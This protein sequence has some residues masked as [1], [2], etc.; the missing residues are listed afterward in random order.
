MD[1]L[2]E[3]QRVWLK[4]IMDITGLRP[5][6]LAKQAGLSTTTLTR[7]LNAEDHKNALSPQ[8]LS[9]IQ[10]V[11]FAL[12]DSMALE[13]AQALAFPDTS[14]TENR[15]FLTGDVA[16][17]ALEHIAYENDALLRQVLNAALQIYTQ[18]TL[19]VVKTRILE[20][21]GYIPGDIIGVDPL[22]EPRNG[23]VVCAQVYDWGNMQANSIL[24]YYSPPF[25]LACE[26]SRVHHPLAIKDQDI[27][28]SGVVVFGYRSRRAWG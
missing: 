27:T 8:T 17:Y 24:R 19:W 18:C 1:A 20:G 12:A 3:R 5:S 11:V 7:F 10:N 16:P 13:D 21:R 2:K 25:L 14:Y 4:K 22:Q 23:D 26:A 6:Q 28:L 15:E 9:A